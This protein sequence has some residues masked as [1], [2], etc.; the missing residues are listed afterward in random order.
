[1]FEYIHKNRIILHISVTDMNK[2]NILQKLITCG[3][4]IDLKLNIIIT[5]LRAFNTV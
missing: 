5:Y 2:T 3:F 1:M 4:K